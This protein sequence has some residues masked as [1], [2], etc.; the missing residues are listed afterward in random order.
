VAGTGFGSIGR[1]KIIFVSAKSCCMPLVRE[2]DLAAWYRAASSQPLILIEGLPRF[3][4]IAPELPHRMPRV[5]PRSKIAAMNQNHYP[6]APPA[7]HLRR[8]RII[9]D[10]F[11]ANC[12]A[13]LS[14][15]RI[16]LLALPESMQQCKLITAGACLGTRSRRMGCILRHEVEQRNCS[17]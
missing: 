14:H 10:A 5:P 3:D 8:H 16:K 6:A 7:R 11:A 13:Q 17:F 12:F 2:N 15:A 4:L 9:S 1:A